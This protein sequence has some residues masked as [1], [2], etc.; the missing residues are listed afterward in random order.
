MQQKEIAALARLAHLHFDDDALAAFAGEFQKTLAF[1][2]Q[3]PALDTEGVDPHEDRLMAAAP[4]RED[5]VRP[6]I[7]QEAA[8]QNAP[9]SDGAGFL[10][11]KVL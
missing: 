6:S 3:L 11:P 7:A 2:D 4:L 8:L 5:E 1:V 10:I 9:Q